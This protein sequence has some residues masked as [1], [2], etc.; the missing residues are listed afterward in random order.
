MSDSEAPLQAVAAGPAFSMAD[1]Q[2]VEE[3]GDA[4]AAG[5]CTV[6]IGAS[7]GGVEALRRLFSAMPVDSGC[8]F[9]VVTHLAPERE[10]LLA[11]LL[12]RTTSMPAQQVDD[13]AVLQPNHIYVAPPA[14]YLD[15]QQG[16]LRTQPIAPRPAKPVAVDHFMLS[17]AADQRERAIGIVLTGADGDGAIGIKGIKSEGGFTIAQLPGSAAHPDMPLH[18]VATGSIDLQLP[19]EEMPAAIAAYVAN[20]QPGVAPAG[21][22]DQADDVLTGVLATVRNA[23]GI[24]FSGYKPPML[25][26]RVRRRM[27]LCRLHDMAAYARLVADSIEEARALTDDFLINVTEFF[28]EPDAWRVMAQDVLPGLLTA[29]EPGSPVRVWVPGCATGEEAYGLAMLLL[30]QPLLQERRLR[31]QIFGTDVDAKALAVARKAHYPRSIETAVGM[32]RLQNFF[33]RTETGYDLRKAVRECVMFAPQ[34]LVF[35]PPFSHMDMV[36]CR[37]LLIYLEPELQRRVLHTLHFALDTGGVLALG[38]S[39]TVS[40]LP[41]LF[42]PVS[43]R[44]RIFRSVGPTRAMAT[45]PAAVPSWR[46]DDA[47]RGTRTL[48]RPVDYGKKVREALLQ[49]H[50]AAAIL[51]DRQGNALYFYGPVQQYL[52]QPEGAPTSDLFSMIDHSLRLQLRA[53]LHK[54]AT[55]G[56]RVEAVAEA[57]SN[58]GDAPV[59]L[60]V[61]PAGSASEGLLLVSFERLDR[62]PEG[63]APPSPESEASMLRVLEDELRNTKH[64]LRSAIEELESTNEELKVANEE[65]MSINEELQSS[66]EELETSK[67]ELQSINEELT[68]VNDQLHAKVL[69]LERVNDD[70]GNLLTSTHIP[71]LF[72]DRDLRIKR[73]TPATTQLFSLL[74][75]DVDR[76]LTD[77]AS[78]S[79]LQALVADARQVLASLAPAQRE[80]RSATGQHY[81]RRTLPYR[82]QD[83]RIEGVVITF[84]DITEIKRAEEGMRRFAA[85]LQASDDAIV[86]LDLHGRVLAWNRGAQTL[87]GHTGAQVMGSEFSALLP[88]AQRAEHAARL[89]DALASG[90]G[91]VAETQRRRAD[92]AVI[93]VASTLS[94]VPDQAGRPESI[95]LTER[96]ITP[97]KAA[98]QV[99]L[100]SEQRFRT[101]ADDAPVLIFMC[102]GDGALQFV[103]AEFAQFVGEPAARL[104]GRRWPALLHGDDQAAARRAMAD[105]DAPGSTQQR[106]SLNVR[107]A[108]ASGRQRW[109]QVTALRTPAGGAAGPGWLGSMVDTDAQVATDQALRLADRRKDELLAMLGHELRNPLVPIRNAAAVLDRV[110]G[111]DPRVIWVRDMLVRQV[112]HITRLVDDL[113]DISLVTRGTLGLHVEPVELR[114]TLEHAIEAVTPLIQRKRHRVEVNLPPEPAWLEGDAIRLTQVFQNLLTNAAK[115]TDPGGLVTIDVERQGEQAVVT[116]RDNGM[117]IA[118]EMLPRIFDLFVQDARSADRSQGGLGIG[119]ALVRRLVELHGG[120]VHASSTGSGQGSQLQVRLPLLPASRV[121]ADGAAAEA[122]APSPG[123]GRVLVVDDDVDGGNSLVLV[124][125]LYGYEAEFA[126]DLQSALSIARTLRPQVV[127]LDIAMPHA[128]GYE[129]ASRL[130]ALPEMAHPVTYVAVTGFARSADYQRSED[131]GF[132]KHM[133]KPVDPDA[134]D[135]L[136]RNVLAFEKD[137]P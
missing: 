58:T 85:V 50:L 41:A 111:N 86:V 122:P 17:L 82:T 79:D 115:Y 137:A 57:E 19:V 35:D 59:R 112:E 65:A 68:S 29:K 13:E 92:G 104:L 26:R 52:R 54:A 95:A 37:N 5:F 116:V 132:S 108:H 128:D 70:I 69:E 28:R 46:V 99:L 78:S 109:V 81:L 39:E 97:A 113:L 130:R 51:I 48:H 135:K 1:A 25:L 3:H 117:G 61:A 129:V 49:H 36:S 40:T 100:D 34:N 84:T 63:A 74:P 45:Q 12:S 119:L 56:E 124:L 106:V 102:D 123:H 134:L 98:Q 55:G 83:D 105:A 96:D 110:A 42:S 103:N 88:D 32:E 114:R 9:V 120:T 73:F 67:E 90:A 72:L 21:Q 15:V 89:R 33:V 62:R 6:A 121:P 43:Q 10:S 38:K 4:T 76:P 20:M 133:I 125:G 11:H 126:P 44:A 136:L 71:T 2:P 75:T 7:A 27:A 94:V 22:A 64:E 118:P 8:A 66:N 107:L 60:V 80:A 77:I 14:K 16:R 30:E 31:L 23:L 101:L 47:G 131:A 53:A 127:L 91:S 24:D 93:D 18:A 87:F